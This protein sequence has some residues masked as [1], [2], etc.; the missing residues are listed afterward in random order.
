MATAVGGGKEGEV[1][2]EDEQKLDCAV[3]QR[4]DRTHAKATVSFQSSVQDA[5]DIFRICIPQI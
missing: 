4:S 2:E 5:F 3:L 1:E